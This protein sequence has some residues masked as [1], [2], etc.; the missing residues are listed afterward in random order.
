MELPKE[1]SAIAALASIMCIRML[2]LFMI[3]PVFSVYAAHIPDATATLIGITLG[4]YGLTQAIFQIPFGMLSDHI[5]RKPVI[6]AGL[7]LLILG[8]IICALSHS[9]YI[10]MFG[11]ALQGAGA[12][13]STVLALVADLTRDTSRG[14]AMAFI[15]LAIGFAFTI[16]M[17]A[18][19]TLNHWFHLSGIFWATGLLALIGMTLLLIVPTPQKPLKTSEKI[20]KKFSM[21]LRDTQI[22]RFN[23]SIFALHLILTALFIAIP[24]LLNRELHLSESRQI[25][26]YVT[27]LLS[28]FIFAVPF[29]ARAERKRKIKSTFIVAISLI[30][31]VQIIFYALQQS[32]IITTILLFVFFAAFTVLEALLPSLV[33]KTAP[34]QNK[35]A[36]MG[37]Y[38]SCQFLGIFAGG[39]LGGFIFSHAGIV[40][41]FALCAGIAAIWL[42]VAIMMRA[43]TYL[44]TL[45]FPLQFEAAHYH[46]LSQLPGVAEIA[47]ASSENLVYIKADKQ[48]ISEPELRNAIEGGNLLRT[49]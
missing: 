49:V 17:I 25:I 26:L 45:V 14:K 27:V 20:G 7:C 9:I 23:F 15:G 31:C 39:S 37:L 8:S 5:G 22:L 1:R 10:L 32:I 40:G 24:I 42:I 2:G 12:I 11:R 16:A 44:T 13:G 4:I 35:G 41:V 36:A 3:L 30:G 28:S 6:F 38:S 29:I 48:K 21:L 33:S 18:G 34:V 46:A 19:P 43:P 47:I